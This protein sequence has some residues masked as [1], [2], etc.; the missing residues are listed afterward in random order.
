MKSARSKATDIPK[1]VKM[2]VYER[3]GGTCVI[4]GKRGFPNAH[5]ISRQRGGL[6]VER[7]IVTLCRECHYAYDFGNAA[8]REACKYI[9]KE[10]LVLKYPDL[11]EKELIFR[12]WSDF[13]E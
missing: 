8:Q 12:K 5:Y 10:Y 1:A 6:G 2:A 4:C 13:N 7:N 11:N 9:I 3:D